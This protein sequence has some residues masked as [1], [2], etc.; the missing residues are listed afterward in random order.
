MRSLV[1]NNSTRCGRLTVE[2]LNH[3]KDSFTNGHTNGRGQEPKYRIAQDPDGVA[4]PAGRVP[5]EG[6]AKRSPPEEFARRGKALEEEAHTTRHIP[7][8]QRVGGD[9]S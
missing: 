6:A 9:R 2:M 3:R 4:R 7:I 8:R 5:R 1:S